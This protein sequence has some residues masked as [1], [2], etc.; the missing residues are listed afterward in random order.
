[1]ATTQQV[2]DAMF[3]VM[4]GGRPIHE[5]MRDNEAADGCRVVLPGDEPWL[6]ASDWHPTVTVSRHGNT[7]RLVAILAKSPGNGA[8]RRTIAGIIDA[9]LV[10]CVVAPT[11]EMR[12]TLKRWKWK[13]R[14]VGYGMDCE[15]QW[16]PRKSFKF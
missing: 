4:N 12:A 6:S 13:C 1:M 8:F 11:M 7:V 15:E 14:H 5:I 10:P 16:R 2:M 9:G 3:A